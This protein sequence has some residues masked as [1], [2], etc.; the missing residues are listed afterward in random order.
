MAHQ[1]REALVDILVNEGCPLFGYACT[2][3]D[4]GANTLDG[5]QAQHALVIDHSPFVRR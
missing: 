4:V 3:A 5:V 1:C 2:V